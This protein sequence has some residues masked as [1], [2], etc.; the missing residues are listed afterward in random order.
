MPSSGIAVWPLWAD[1]APPPEPPKAAEIESAPPTE[2][3]PPARDDTP[4]Y[5]LIVGARAWISHGRSAHNVGYPGGHPNV[6]SEL[7]WRGMN[8][9]I[10]QVEGGSDA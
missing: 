4:P 8:S 2:H 1:D 10:T 5:T 9:V 6:L 3:V 7:T